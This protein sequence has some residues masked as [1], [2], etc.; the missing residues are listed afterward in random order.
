MPN[1][2][3]KIESFSRI[4]TRKRDL[5]RLYTPPPSIFQNKFV[6]SHLQGVV[7][8]PKSASAS[9]EKRSDI[10]S[11]SPLKGDK[12]ADEHQH[13]ND[14]RILL[15]GEYSNLHYTLGEALREAGHQVLLVSDGDGWKNYPRDINLQRKRTGIRGSIPYVWKLFRLLPKL[16]GFD[17]VQLINPVFLDLKP[18]WNEWVFDYLRKHNRRVSLGLFGDDTNILHKTQNNI[19]FKYTDLYAGGRRISHPLNR[20]RTRTWFDPDRIY[21]TRYISMRADYLIA[22]LYEYHKIY[23]T[24]EYFRRLHYAPLPI[25]T[26]DIPSGFDKDFSNRRIKVLIGIQ[27]RRGLMKGTDQMLP[28]FEKLASEH[29]GLIELH[30]VESVP[31]EEYRRLLKETD[32]LVDQLYSYTPAMNAL[33][34]MK[35]GVIV[36]SGGEEEA[37]EFI[38]EEELRP[39][40][41]LRPMEDERNYRKLEFLLQR[42]D[43]LKRMATESITYIRKH[44]DARKVAQCYLRIWNKE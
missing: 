4:T 42:P 40:I 7:R 37:Y 25:D 19:Y 29:P 27:K 31:F 12:I 21:L 30:C 18:R 38:G 6:F 11:Y 34:A 32:I 8:Q 24:Q 26:C 13:T 22:C 5:F 1:R 41:N 3:T 17:V 10:R 44:H 43:Q 28:L 35:H 9:D 2:D 39:I 33:E 20:E 23:D 15:L 16:R 14:M 36:V